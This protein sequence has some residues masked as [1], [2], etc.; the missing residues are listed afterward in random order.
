VPQPDPSPRAREIAGRARALLDVEGPEALTMRRLADELGMRAPSLYKHFAS[1]EVLEAAV[2]ALCLEDLAVRFEAAVADASRPDRPA[3]LAR[4]YRC[5][6]L[7]H[8]HEYRLV[9]DRPLP[10][11]LLPDGLEARTAAPLVAAMGSPDRARAAWAFAHG[12][13]SLELNGRFPPDADLDAAWAAGIAGLR[14]AS[15]RT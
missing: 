8:P 1:K 7:A 3:A 10:R 12:M 6:A 15:R 4:A 2:V 5:Y 14:P 9:N 11:D 13:V